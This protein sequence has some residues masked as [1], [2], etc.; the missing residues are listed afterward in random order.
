[1]KRSLLVAG[2]TGL[3][4][5]AVVELALADQRFGRVITWG[6]RAM[7][8]TNGSEHW[9]PGPVSLIEGLRNER[10]DAVICCLGT[11][12]RNVKGDKK[13]F[14]HVDLELVLALARWAEGSDTRFCLVSALGADPN[15]AFFYNRVKG[16]VEMDLR[17][18]TFQALHIFRPSILDGPRKEDRP[19][20]RAGL[21]LMK[22]LAPLL[23]TRSRP[24][25]YR[26]LAKALLSAAAGTD[27]GVHIHT[28]AG[29]KALAG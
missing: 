13:A 3:V 27:S 20:E 23:P 25:P 2:A 10:V 1:M 9:A 28:T 4:G 8:N 17:R 26:T 7:P 24:M 6:R 19:G 5:S 22:F 16:R 18:L 15:S 14:V 29:I 21:V 11:T 12:M